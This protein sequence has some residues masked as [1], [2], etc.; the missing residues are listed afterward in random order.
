[1][2]LYDYDTN[3]ILGEAMPDRKSTTLKKSFLVLC[4][5]LC[6]KGHKPKMHRLDNEMSANYTTIVE[7]IDV[8]IRSYT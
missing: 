5:K 2:V 3:E 6:K 8:T 4:N 7:K 1:M